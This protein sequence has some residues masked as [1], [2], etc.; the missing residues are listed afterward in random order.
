MFL[1][2][3]A[4]R[5]ID[6]DFRPAVHNSEGLA[7]WNGMGERLWRP[8]TNPMTLQTSAFVDKSPKGFGLCQ[9]TRAFQSYEDLE[10]RFDRRPTAWV[11]PKGAWGDGYVE[12]IEIPV[13][14]E[15]H[16][17]IVVYWKPAS[18]LEA[19]KPFEIS[20]RLSW[21][22]DIPVAWT[23]AKVARTHVSGWR[24]E[25]TVL[26]VIDFDGPAVAELQELPAAELA[27]S[28]GEVANLLVQRHPEIQGLRIR[29]ELQTGG[30]EVIE[31]RL[32][33]KLAGQ[34]ISESWLYRWT[35]S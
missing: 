16:D 12:L 22:A 18:P 9:R 33:L 10:A 8:L 5:R 27:V 31:L 28:A 23:G 26:F 7:V 2:G 15:I 20:Y 32:G 29:F 1:H 17:N 4:H 34:L 25:G 14:E 13:T 19:G 11:E 6:R 35:K 30:T 21:G 3:S 24:G